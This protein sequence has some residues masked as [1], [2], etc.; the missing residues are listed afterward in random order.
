MYKTKTFL[1]VTLFSIVMLLTSTSH[2]QNFV[3]QVDS[4]TELHDRQSPGSAFIDY[5]N[6]GDLD[7][8]VVNIISAFTSAQATNSL[9]KNDG[10]GNFTPVTEGEIVTGSFT[11]YGTSWADYDNDGDLDAF[12]SGDSS[13]L[14]RNDGNDTFVKITEGEIGDGFGNRGWAC[15]WGD[16]N[17]DGNIDLIVTHANGFSSVGTTKN[18]LF[19]NNGDG[20]FTKNIRSA[21]SNEF[22]AY[23]TPTWF[24]YDDDGDIDLFVAIG[25]ANGTIVQQAIY[26]NMLSESG[27]ATLLE[28]DLG[29]IS[30]D[31][32]D[33]Q[34]LNFADVDNDGDL[35]CYITSFF[36]TTAN[37]FYRNDNGVYVRDE[38]SA[39]TKYPTPSLASM[40]G[41]Y[42]NDGDLDVIVSS[43]SHAFG[44]DR[45]MYF[46]NVGGGVYQ[47]RTD[48]GDLSENSSDATWGGSNGDIDNDGDL[49]LYIPN[50]GSQQFD[51]TNYLYKNDLAGN[52]NW[53]NIRLVGTESNRAAIGTRV[54][55]MLEVNGERQIMRR[56]ISAQNTFSGHNSLRAHFGLGDAQTVDTLRIMWPSGYVN[57]YY[58]VEANQFL[59][60]EEMESLTSTDDD[61]SS[62]PQE[63]ELKQNYPNPFNPSTRISFTLPARSFVTLKVYD[64]TGR[65]VTT[66]LSKELSAGT[67]FA[68]WNGTSDTGERVSSGVYLYK[69]DAFGNNNSSFSASAKMMLLK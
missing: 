58:D 40:F 20:T 39:L 65:L 14:Y 28:H 25:P 9:F 49:D 22:A 51:F 57:E 67:N 38:E 55:A 29:P 46:E 42:D 8:F 12:A 26:K 18:H 10:N 24:D 48:V 34:T 11:S 7:L 1:Y 54:F 31:M 3:R 27:N 32:F 16:Y 43:G 6:D 56:D 30:E 50:V 4:P 68:E 13:Y 23:T 35:D 2:S 63:F 62:L 69:L 36:S 61:L 21:V 53:L 41:D 59:E 45:N 44:S 15:A 47:E 37:Q 66:I 52:N 60:Y 64:V 5:D 17:N 33:G 19:S